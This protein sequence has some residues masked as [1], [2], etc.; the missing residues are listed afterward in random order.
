MQVTTNA[1]HN[2]RDKTEA[3]WILLSVKTLKDITALYRGCAVR[4]LSPP[5]PPLFDPPPPPFEKP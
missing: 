3:M 2:R 4:P 5:P 1:P